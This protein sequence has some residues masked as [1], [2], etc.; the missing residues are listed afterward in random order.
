VDSTHNANRPVRAT[1]ASVRLFVASDTSSS[2]GSAE[3]EATAV[4]VQ[5][6]GRPSA[7]LVTTATPVGQAAIRSRNLS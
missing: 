3:T 1:A 6:T 2:G 5:P 4:T 7:A